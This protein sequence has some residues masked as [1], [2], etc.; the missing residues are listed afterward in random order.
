M[1]RAA[2]RVQA[3]AI[4]A[5]G[6]PLGPL[7]AGVLER[8][9]AWPRDRL[10]VLTYHRV[11]PRGLRPDLHPGLVSADPEAFREQ[12]AWLA[13]HA[14]VV[15]LATV[16][17]AADGEPLPPRSVLITFDD[18]YADV[19]EH[20]WPLLRGL[21][22]PAVLF[23][24]TGAPG[25]TAAFW[26][27]RLY[28][29]IELGSR[30]PLVRTD[31]G[32]LRLATA[33]G[34][35]AAF[36]A[37]RERAKRLPHDEAMAMV[38][39]LVAELRGPAVPSAVL[40][41]AA[42]RRLAAEGL[43]LAPHTRSHPILP[44]IDD[45]RLRLELQLPLEDLRREV[46]V[47]PPVLA[48]PSGIHDGRVRTAAAEAGYRLALTTRRGAIRSLRCADPMALPRINVGGRTTLALLRMQ[49]APAWDRLT[50]RSGA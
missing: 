9:Q 1:I 23:V 12:V 39:A 20:A 7:A 2:D 5:T 50:G 44:M 26:W 4:R 10:A 25:G 42:L 37:I 24:P 17:R 33:E 46:G 16:L 40:D 11:A 45:A 34:R 22:L 48:Y 38:D 15:D 36:S 18:A 28:A 41:W 31:A 6:G 21:G 8:A 30:P 13:R 29:A 3:L 27:D 35:A 49:L 14:T 47:V 32:D 43:M 19:A